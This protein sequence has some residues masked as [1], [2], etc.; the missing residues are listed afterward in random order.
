MG[1]QNLYEEFK[2]PLVVAS[3][4]I[5]HGR[6]DALVYL[7]DLFPTC[8][9]LAGVPISPEL[10]GASLAPIIRGDRP[11]V[12]AWLFAAYRDCQRM[13]RDE[14][15]KLFWYP[16]VERFQLFDLAS[17]PWEIDDLAGKPEHSARLAELTKQLAAEQR[18]FDDPHAPPR[19]AATRP[20]QH[21]PRAA[22]PS[23]DDN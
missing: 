18:R 9:E 23:A 6:S 8:C 7:F 19:L 11:R 17:D 5:P 14:Q 15:W 16:R 21:A 12:R 1:K 10:E 4:G 3:P 22:Q 13:V 20:A 2:S